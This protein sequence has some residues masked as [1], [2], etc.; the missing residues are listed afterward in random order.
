LPW[1]EGEAG[2]HDPHIWFDVS[3]WAAAVPAVREL[4][5]TADPAGAD[6]YRA[7]AAAFETS[8]KALH[9]EVKSKLATV[10]AERRVLITSHDAYG[11]FGKAYGMEVRGIQGISTET[12]AG[13]REVNGA[14][15][16]IVSHKIPAIFVETSVSPK[17]IEQ[18][19]AACKAR[20]HQV[21]VGAE[22]FSDAM[23]APGQ[24]PPYAVETYEG[25]VR[26]N[27]DSI[28]KDLK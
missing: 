8:L 3:L 13:L 23:G 25:M 7:N 18:V 6:V 16:F 22:L 24:H 26:Y 9:E 4:L 17:T 15:D 27:V 20:G 19:A 28:V 21:K 5:I 2:A 11:Y 14:V 10:P 1:Q 12:E